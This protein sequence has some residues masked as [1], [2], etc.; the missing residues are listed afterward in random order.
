MTHPTRSQQ[1]RRRCRRKEASLLG[2]EIDPEAFHE[3][4]SS[5]SKARIPWRGQLAGSGVWHALV[6]AG[7]G[8]GDT[9]YCSEIPISARTRPSH[10]LYRH[11]ADLS[12]V[13]VDGVGL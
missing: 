9:V 6:R 10:L 7:P 8:V 5:P 1:T 3:P 11:G 12:A 13:F 2:Q 4:L